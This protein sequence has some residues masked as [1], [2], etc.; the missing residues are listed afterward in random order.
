M[1]AA[2]RVSPSMHILSKKKIN[3]VLFFRPFSSIIIREKVFRHLQG[4]DGTVKKSFTLIELLV[5][6][7]IIAILASILLP[8][9]G[10]AR[11]KAKSSQCV[12]NLRQL[13][14]AIQQYVS[15][16]DF[17]PCLNCTAFKGEDKAGFASWKFCLAPYL[18]LDLPGDKA[19]SAKNS[20]L[21]EGIFKCPKF[22]YE[23]LNKGYHPVDS[24]VIYGGGYG[25]N[26][27]H[28]SGIGYRAAG[29]TIILNNGVQWWVK[30]SQ[31]TI[32][33]E[34]LAC[35]DGIDDPGHPY[36]GANSVQA[37][38]VMYARAEPFRHGTSFGV[39]WVDGHATMEK[40][41][42]IMQGKNSPTNAGVRDANAY[43]YYYFRNK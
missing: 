29:S 39:T 33:S 20:A 28:N 23:Q 13:G 37:L 34:T 16:N 12:G 21:A 38:S 2:G 40:V 17:F 14:L 26:W 24:N 32:P 3:F 18:S 6:I 10:Q 4:K 43:K 8:A 35:G 41:Y 11:E 15:D 42:T 5:V 22:A 30:P 31:V 27:G 25:Y 36:S 7:A 19:Q 9:L 1:Q